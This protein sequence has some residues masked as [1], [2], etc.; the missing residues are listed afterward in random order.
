MALRLKTIINKYS[1]LLQYWE[2]IKD[3]KPKIIDIYRKSYN[4][5]RTLYYYARDVIKGRWPEAEPH[6]KVDP[7]WAYWYASD[8]IKGRWPEAEPYI[9]KNSEWAY[10]YAR[11]VIK[12]RW[13]EVEPII[14]VNPQFAYYYARDVIKGRWPEAEPYIKNSEWANSY[15]DFIDSL[16]RK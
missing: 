5:P 7:R 2:V 12:G 13:P 8:V 1:G 6:I 3:C 9:M 10:G 11:F 15:N 14:K 4:I 16:K